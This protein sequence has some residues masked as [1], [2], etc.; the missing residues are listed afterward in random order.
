ML[1]EYHKHLNEHSVS[2]SVVIYHARRCPEPF[3]F[4]VYPGWFE[5]LRPF[6]LWVHFAGL[7]L[8]YTD[9]YWGHHFCYDQHA[10][11]G[12]FLK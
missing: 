3:I 5:H 6:K 1:A 2:V 9:F 8:V 12:N 7:F 4:Y 10:A 11:L